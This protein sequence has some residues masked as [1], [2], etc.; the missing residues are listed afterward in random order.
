VLR[1]R[2]LTDALAPLGDEIAFEGT[3]RG[4]DWDPALA[5]AQGGGFAMSWTS[6]PV[7]DLVRDAVV[8][9]F[10]GRGRPSAPVQTVCYSANEQD[11]TS[12]T[13]LANGDFAVAWEDD[14]SFYDHVY[15]RRLM[16]NGRAL[17][18]LMRINALETEF[19]PDRVAPRVAAMGGGFAAVF[20][21]RHRSRGFDA[22]IKL[23]GPAFDADLKR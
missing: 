8:C 18:P 22:L 12:I 23:V 4:G 15:V 3:N 6:A 7:T 11:F 19:L 10:D 13:R 21:D 2:F 9:L 20:S 5:P 1:A 17:G 16:K 14:I